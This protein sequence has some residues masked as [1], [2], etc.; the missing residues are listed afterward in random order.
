MWTTVHDDCVLHEFHA[1]NRK[2]PFVH[3]HVWWV[4]VVSEGGSGC[5]DRF[6]FNCWE[7]FKQARSYERKVHSDNGVAIICS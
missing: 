2:C 1:D 4:Y 5:F 6:D 3:V 7:S